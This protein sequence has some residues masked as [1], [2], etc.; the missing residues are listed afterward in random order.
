MEYKLKHTILL[1]IYLYH[2]TWKQTL[3]Q[4]NF[5]VI[6]NVLHRKI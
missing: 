6:C 1:K 2:L 3:E 5:N 4:A